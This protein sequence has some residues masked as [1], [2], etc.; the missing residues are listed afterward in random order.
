MTRTVEQIEAEI[1]ALHAELER[2]QNAH[3]HD[4]WAA[5]FPA[6]LGERLLT[7]AHQAAARTT[8]TY[9]G[10]SS[11]EIELAPGVTVWVQFDTNLPEEIPGS[12]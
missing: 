6:D 4:R 2:V 8:G 12:M 3:W 9:H 10:G 11:D 7:A 1:A 5:F